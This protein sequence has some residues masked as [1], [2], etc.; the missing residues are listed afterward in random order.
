MRLLAA[1]SAAASGVPRTP[2][3]PRAGRAGPRSSPGARRARRPP[4]S[5]ITLIAQVAAH[6]LVNEID[7]GVGLRGHGGNRVERVER[8]RHELRQ[9]NGM[10]PLDQDAHDAK[11]RAAQS[12][13]V[14]VAGRDLTDSEHA[15]HRL[16]LVGERHRLRDR[17]FRQVATGGLGPV[18]LLDRGGDHGRSRRRASRSSVHEPLQ[19]GKL[20]DHVGDEIRLGKSG[21]ALRGRGVRADHRRNALREEA[22]AIDAIGLAAELVVIDDGSQAIHARFEPLPPVLVE[23][24]LG[25]GQACAQHA[26][27]AGDDGRRVARFEVAH[28]EE[29]V[30]ELASVVGKREEALVELHRQNEAFLW[31][32]EERRVERSGIDDRPFDERRHLI[33]QRVGH[34]RRALPAAP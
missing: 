18:V 2:G 27:V 17:A 23:E 22:Q 6:P 34:D 29:A 8:K 28:H 7:D 31:H 16:E 12:E 1:D 11:R 4:G 9:R 20:A 30:D 5:R 33:E 13:R 19:L 21:R 3:P 32:R 24:E 25:V 10:L 26:L 14:L 15:R